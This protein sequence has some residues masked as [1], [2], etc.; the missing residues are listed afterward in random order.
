MSCFIVTCESISAAA[1]IATCMN[2]SWIT[3]WS[4]EAILHDYIYSVL[5]A[6]YPT[7]AIYS[8]IDHRLCFISQQN[9]VLSA[10]DFLC[11]GEPRRWLILI[12]VCS[13]YCF[14]F[15]FLLNSIPPIILQTVVRC[16]KKKFPPKS[17]SVS[18][19]NCFPSKPVECFS[20][21]TLTGHCLGDSACALHSERQLNSW[22]H[23]V[24][25]HILWHMSD[26][27]DP[28]L[29]LSSDAR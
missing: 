5:V 17:I 25:L 11:T 9:Q 14:L 18:K 10:K 2:R 8:H 24:I 1:I 13:S 21:L 16:Y 3:N 19:Y 26:N 12:C 15:L 22:H 20:W 28:Y 7:K 4:R 27:T 23:P 29:Q 6:A